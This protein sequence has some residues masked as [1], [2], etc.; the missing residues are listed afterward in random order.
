M[1]KRQQERVNPPSVVCLNG[2][3]LIPTVFGAFSGL[4]LKL[5]TSSN[6]CKK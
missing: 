6:G 5:K 1:E 3:K 2:I 4:V